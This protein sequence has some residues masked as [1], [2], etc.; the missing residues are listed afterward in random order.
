[1]TKESL[2]TTTSNGG[3][4]PAR[5]VEQ[6]PARRQAASLFEDMQTDL[7]RL[8]EG[9]PLRRSLTSAM[10]MPRVDVYEKDGN[11]MIA[12]ELPGIKKEDIDLEIEEGDLILRAERKEE[13]EVEEE[14]WYRM[15][16]S[17][18]QLYR[19]V[20]LPEG[21]QVDKISATLSDGV[22]TVTIPK[23]AETEKKARKI[24][25]SS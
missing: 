16:R 8:F 23:P 13:H 17:T 14:N 25:I 7:L 1:M 18:G 4:S 19:R 11:L 5:H 9:W 6:K 10:A 12:A 2:A 3:T 15:E 24:E 22:L 21:A 20:P